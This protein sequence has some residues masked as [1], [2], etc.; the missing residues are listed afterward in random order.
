MFAIKDQDTELYVSAKPYK[1]SSLK[2]ARLFS[3]KEEIEL[4]LGNIINELVWKYLENKYNSDRWSLDVGFKE[5][6]D[7]IKIY[8]RMKIVKVSTSEST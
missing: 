1:L 7:V 5:F 3:N 6:S 2:C 8:S 4:I